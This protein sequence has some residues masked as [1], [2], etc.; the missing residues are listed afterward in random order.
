VMATVASSKNGGGVGMR[1]K[2]AVP[3]VPVLPAPLTDEYMAQ[4]L[5]ELPDGTKRATEA[6]LKCFKVGA[7]SGSSC[8]LSRS[9]NG[10]WP[11]HWRAIGPPGAPSPPCDAVSHSHRDRG[12]VWAAV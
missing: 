3:G 12:P 5:R 11:R 2:T 10:P 9:E 1:K 6:C 8:P 4:A 7:D